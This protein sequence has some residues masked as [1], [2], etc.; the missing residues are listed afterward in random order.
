MAA[1]LQKKNNLKQVL[2]H[3]T[4]RYASIKLDKKKEK[5]EDD[6][7]RGL[8]RVFPSAAIDSSVVDQ[9]PVKSEQKQIEILLGAVETVE[10]SGNDKASLTYS[11]GALLKIETMHGLKFPEKYKKIIKNNLNNLIRKAERLIKEKKL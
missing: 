6:P 2:D 8:N 5:A 9:I 10:Q 4:N 7:L 1:V 3:L 11:E